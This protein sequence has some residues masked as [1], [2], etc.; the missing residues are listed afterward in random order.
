MQCFVP[1]LDVILGCESRAVA[2][3][4]MCCMTSLPNAQAIREPLLPP[5]HAGNLNYCMRPRINIQLIKYDD[6]KWSDR[7]TNRTVVAMSAGYSF[8]GTLLGSKQSPALPNTV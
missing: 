5:L 6:E 4:F 7:Q 1:V 8:P 3:C 2:L